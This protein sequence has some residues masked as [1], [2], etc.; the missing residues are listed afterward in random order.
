MALELAQ[1][2]CPMCAQTISSKSTRARHLALC[3]PDLIDPIGWK[4][5]D[6]N[7]VRD[8]ASRRHPKSSFRWA[9]LSRRFGWADEVGTGAKAAAA[10]NYDDDMP[11]EYDTLDAMDFEG[12]EDGYGG[13]GYEN[14][15]TPPRCARRR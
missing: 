11:D 2:Q 4:N 5:G 3:C 6:S 12:D 15:P 14:T 9:V 1:P 8:F 13:G 10:A 7:V